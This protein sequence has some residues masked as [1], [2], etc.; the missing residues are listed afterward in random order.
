M[1]ID[2][3]S[4]FSKAWE[5]MTNALFR[6]F[7]I[8]KWFVL[9]FTAFLAQ[10]LD[11]GFGGWNFPGSSNR[12]GGTNIP[13]IGRIPERTADWIHAHPFLVAAILMGIF[14]FLAII[15]VLTW[16]SSRGTFMF[17]D[18]VVHNRA[19]VAKPWREYQI[20]GDSLF[21]WR[22]GFGIVVTL[23][24]L[25]SLVVL[26]FLIVQAARSHYTP[27]NIAGIII[28]GLFGLLGSVVA[29]YISLFTHS[30]VVPIMYRHKLRILQ[31]WHKFLPILKSHFIYFILYG[32]LF[33]LLF[34]VIGIAAFLTGCLTCC[35]A[36]IIM[37]IPYIGSVFL[38]P[39]SFTL[40]AF[41]LEFLAQWGADY[42][43]FYEESSSPDNVPP[44]PLP[45]PSGVNG[46]GI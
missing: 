17:L 40:R 45:S 33:F 9:G 4:P 3:F 46:S 28:I 11:G 37:S 26:F 14:I 42:S 25:T 20:Q 24:V 39:V 18:N 30:F 41:S 5:R 22:V 38:L 8:G 34:I 29:G 32:L 13:D 21:L 31:A 7:D 23:L 19:L 44:P 15:L 43:V 27:Q 2:Y 10:L 1:N 6:P 36:F 35:I 16:L 12:G